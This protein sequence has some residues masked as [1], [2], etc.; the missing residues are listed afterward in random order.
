MLTATDMT[1]SAVEEFLVSLGKQ[2]PTKSNLIFCELESKFPTK[3][4]D[5]NE[6]RAAALSLLKICSS[7][8]SSMLGNSARALQLL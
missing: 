1:R 2:Y 7:A 3:Y 5:A 8:S 4:A 6:Q